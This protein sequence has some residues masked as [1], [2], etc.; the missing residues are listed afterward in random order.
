VPTLITACWPLPNDRGI[1]G[2]GGR[3]NCDGGKK[4]REGRR[5]G[6]HLQSFFFQ[7][8]PSADLSLDRPTVLAWER[9]GG[10]KTEEGRGEREERGD[11]KGCHRIVE[12]MHRG[13]IL[14]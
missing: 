7:P 13:Q 3:K 14:G 10:E 2:R 12:A 8:C 11:G 4:G 5:E 1:E 6:R 9:R